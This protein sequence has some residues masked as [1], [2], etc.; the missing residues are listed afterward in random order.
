MTY[1][2][3]DLAYIGHVFLFTELSLL[4]ILLIRVKR[5]SSL[6]ISSSWIKR[7]LSFGYKSIF[8]ELT[9][10]MNSSV[11]VLL[12]GHFLGNT[13][14]GYFSFYEVFAKSLLMLS[15]AVQKNFNSVFSNLWS[16]NE[17]EKIQSYIYKI[18]KFQVLSIGP[19]L[20]IVTISAYIYT[21]YF[22]EIHFLNQFDI[23]LV[24]LSGVVIVYIYA[25]FGGLLIMAEFLWWNLLRTVISLSI[26]VLLLLLLIQKVGVLGAPLAFTI[27]SIFELL[28]FVYLF[29]NLLGLNLPQIIYEKVALK[30]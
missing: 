11:P 26:S 15:S 14:A 29:K 8:S 7:H 9:S 5:F 20:A 22:M 19:I 16:N 18:I 6:R 1:R 2:A 12:V 23:L 17:T 30:S 25:P 27:G 13:A 21:L 3:M 4:L 24:Y 10:T 28:F